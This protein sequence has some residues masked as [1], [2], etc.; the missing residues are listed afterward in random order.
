MKAKG[1]ATFTQEQ[2]KSE[3]IQRQSKNVFPLHVFHEKIRPFLNALNKGYDLPA[4]YLGTTLLSAYSTSI[5][6][7]YKI[8]SGNEDF[9]YL[10]VWTCLCGI[11]SSGGTTVINKLFAPL[12]KIQSDF[13]FDWEKKTNGLSP[14]KRNHEIM[15]TVIYRDSHIPTLVRTILPDNQKGV[16]KHSDE[17][18]EWIN[19]MNQLSKR[20]GTDEQFWISAWNCTPY[21]GIRSG[22]DKFVI[23]RPFV[24]VIGKAQYPI[25][26]KLFAK[27]RDTTGFIFRMLFALPEEDKIS[28]RESDFVMPIEWTELHDRSLTRLYKDLQV[29]DA[30]EGRCCTIDPAAKKIL[31][32]WRREKTR[33]INALDDST[34]KNI[35]AGILGKVSEYVYRFAA[36]L[37]LADKTFD[38]DYEGDFH[39]AFRQNE[40]ISMDTMRRALE[41][42]DYFY[43]SGNEVYDLVQKSLSAPPEVLTT[44]FM[45]RRGK[46]HS[47][48]G[49]MLY[50]SKTDKYK[51]RAGRQIKKWIKEYPRV[52]G[53]YSK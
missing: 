50:G 48:I 14:D 1:L 28:Q 39:I 29:F 2:L 16:C 46:S 20:E 7:A 13:D 45:M 12:F 31:D 36:I 17:L 19:G 26:V 10:P 32:Q 49:E 6:T 5:G 53:A 34:E 24:N 38:Q 51:V 8:D 33:F 42:A 35:K 18:L 47:E 3:V 27:D 23:P 37:H 43:E 9:I 21:S 25:L 22:K 30:D 44:F 11:S 40:L 52:F 4:S 15:E 41:L